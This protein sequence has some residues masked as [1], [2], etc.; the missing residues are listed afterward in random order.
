MLHL[1][2]GYPDQTDVFITPSPSPAPFA[3][4]V[5]MPL[6]VLLGKMS[7]FTIGIPH[8]H[9]KCLSKCMGGLQSVLLLFY[10]VQ[11]R[12]H[13]SLGGVFI[14]MWEDSFAENNITLA[15]GIGHWTAPKL[16][17]WDAFL[18]RT[19]VWSRNR[20]WTLGSPCVTKVF[21]PLKR[22]VIDS[23]GKQPWFTHPSSS[24]PYRGFLFSC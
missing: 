4:S 23:R 13:L 10:T 5:Q 12:V 2:Y 3:E 24:K 19:I 7:C 14:I 15:H 9:E 11:L 17:V 6:L 16:G 21:M 20:C 8:R 22:S 18:S 1:R